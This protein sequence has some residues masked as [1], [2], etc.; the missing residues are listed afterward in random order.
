MKRALPLFL[1]FAALITGRK[2][3][4]IK[5]LADNNSHPEVSS[6]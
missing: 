4:N 6:P 3:L 2:E 1:L 5:P